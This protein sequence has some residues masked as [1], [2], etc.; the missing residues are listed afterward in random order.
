[1]DIQ[2]KVVGKLIFNERLPW[3]CCEPL[4]FGWDMVY[5]GHIYSSSLTWA[6]AATAPCSTLALMKEEHSTPSPVAQCKSLFFHNN[7]AAQTHL[8]L[9]GASKWNEFSLISA[10]RFYAETPH[11]FNILTSFLKRIW[12]KLSK[13]FSE[14]KIGR[15]LWHLDQKFV[16]PLWRKFLRNGNWW[17]IWHWHYKCYPWMDSTG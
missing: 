12:V 4:K 17:M 14:L 10:H 11:E 5:L 15:F 9:K 6:F 3:P 13:S 16:L 1:M 2:L 8:S 7:A